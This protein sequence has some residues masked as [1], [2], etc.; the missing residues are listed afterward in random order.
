MAEYKARHQVKRWITLISATVLF[1]AVLFLLPESIDWSAR[2]TISI[3]LYALILWAFAPI[4]IGLTSVFVL[5][6]L[7]LLKPVGMETV[8]SGFASPA[9]FLIIGGMMMAIGVNH[10]LL[11]KR[12]TYSLLAVMGKSTKGIYIGFTILMQIQA[13]FIPATAVRATLMMPIVSN[14]I[15]ETG[16]SKNSNFS[17][18]M[19]IGSAFGGNISGVAVLTA[20]IGNILAVEILRLYADVSISYLQWFIYTAPIWILL[21]IV[22]M[23][24]VWK[25][26]PPEVETFENLHKEMK[27][28][29]NELGKLTLDEKKCMAIL[30]F[31]IILWFT[32]SLHGYHP[33]F[34]ALLAVI[35]MALPGTGFIEWRK[36]LDVN[37]GMILLLG[38]TLSLGYSLIESGAI[39]LLETLVSPQGVIDVFSNPWLAIPIV[40]I[41]SQV[42]HLGVTNVS[43]AVITMLPVLISL[44]VQAGLDPVVMSV[45]SA[46][47]LLL[48]FLLVVETMPNVVAHSTGRV[49]QKDFL[50]PGILATLASIVIMVLVAYTYWRWIGF[51]P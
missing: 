18:L 5:M 32:E 51:W 39:D 44:S 29:N 2:S 43:T 4:P 24:I 42:Y 27:N 46:V 3:M 19:Y 41:L 16:V 28:K 37:F 11:I 8:F 49:T 35:L 13:F 14:I 22:V 40:I 10:T 45:T 34:A 50:W 23:Y 21:V 20:A 38:A 25:C 30:G 9:I 12:M 17:K 48:G 47:S 36:L 1:L 31:T 7:L 6:L 26:Y 33:T 15:E